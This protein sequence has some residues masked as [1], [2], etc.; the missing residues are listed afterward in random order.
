MIR[1]VR[2]QCGACLLSATLASAMVAVQPPSA[3]ASA[4]GLRLQSAHIEATAISLLANSA[5]LSIPENEF[6]SPTASAVAA[7]EFVKAFESTGC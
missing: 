2:Q 4:V 3:N 7:S 6:T 1:S 5:A